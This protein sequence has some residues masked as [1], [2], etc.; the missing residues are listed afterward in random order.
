MSLAISIITAT[1]NGELS[2]VE[3]RNDINELRELISKHLNYTGSKKAK[4]ILDEFDR[5][6]PMFIKVIPYDYKRVIEE[7]K[8]EELKKKIASVEIDVD[9]SGV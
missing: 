3:D 6:L 1:W 7:Q 2:L 5:F 4:M 9:I 8:L